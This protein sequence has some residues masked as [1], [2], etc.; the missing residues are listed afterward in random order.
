VTPE[1]VAQLSHEIRAARV[2]VYHGGFPGLQTG[3]AL[4]SASVTQSHNLSNVFRE[5]NPEKQIRKD[6]IYITTDRFIAVGVAAHC[7]K[8][9]GFE[10]NWCAVYQVMIGPDDVEIDTDTPEGPNVTF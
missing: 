2:Q 8:R 5:I 4:P 7:A 3:D 9:P 6:R 10:N 1:E